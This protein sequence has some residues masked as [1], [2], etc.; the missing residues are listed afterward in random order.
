MLELDD[1]F[2]R[3]YVG[4]ARR[5]KVHNTLSLPSNDVYKKL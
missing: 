3:K 4:I 1:C 5:K 2:R